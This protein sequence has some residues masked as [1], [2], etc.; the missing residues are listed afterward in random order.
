MKQDENILQQLEDLIN[1]TYVIEK[2]YINL[3]Q[4]YQQMQDTFEQLMNFLPN[5]LW[6]LENDKHVFLQNNKA[7]ELSRLL[8][9]IDIKE[10]DYELAFEERFFLIKTNR[11][12]DKTLINATDITEQKRKDR[13][14][15]MGQ[16]A[17][18]L[19]HEIRNPIGSIS[20]LTSTLLK[21]VDIK[22]KPI[23]FEVQKAVFR[24]ERIIKATLMFSK[25][26]NAQ[27]NYFKLESIQ[28]ELERAIGYYTYTKEIDFEI[29]F[30]DVELYADSDLL[31]MMLSN[32]IFN[33]ID[34]IEE[35]EKEEGKV[36]VVYSNN[37]DYHIFDISDDGVGIEDKNI[38]FEAF[39]SSKEKGNG[40]GLILSQQIAHAHG[41]RVDLLQTEAKTFRLTLSKK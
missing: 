7:K 28:E 19:S 10:K 24:I 17:A 32:F 3:N 26:V 39:K 37:N 25:G 40:L 22:N 29:D 13:L 33:A 8:E 5:A 34:A 15:T 12:K 1:Q 11:Y 41:G 30:Q 36:S 38:L 16:M 6:V 4:S 9:C 23:V 20:L 35:D 2:E 18:H 27:K 21:R 14:A 31:I